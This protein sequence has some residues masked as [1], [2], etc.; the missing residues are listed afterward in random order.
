MRRFA[1]IA[2][3]A[4]LPAAA[5]VTSPSGRTVDCYCTDSQ[6]GRVEMGERTCLSV[7]GR[8]FMARCDM[9]LNV[10]IWRDTGESCVTG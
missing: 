8:V 2:C 1:L 10:P 4:A 6:G 7:G 3:F 9:S 5:E